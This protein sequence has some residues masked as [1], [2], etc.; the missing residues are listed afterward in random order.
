MYVVVTTNITN[1]FMSKP[2]V[3]L[4]AIICYNSKTTTFRYQV[5]F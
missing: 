4:L 3:I 5:D 1:I 2:V